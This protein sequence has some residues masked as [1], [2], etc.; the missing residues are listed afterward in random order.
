MLKHSLLP[1]WGMSAL[2]LKVC[3]ATVGLTLAVFMPVF[4]TGQTPPTGGVVTTQ[5]EF[6]LKDLEEGQGSAQRQPLFQAQKFLVAG[7]LDE[8]EPLI[9][10]V[11][12]YFD[13]ETAEKAVDYVSVASREQLERY[14]KEHPGERKIV[15][16]DWS[17]GWALH[18]KGWIAASRRRLPEAEKWL[19]K[20]V[21][22]RPYA[23]E[24][25]VELGYVQTQAGRGQDGLKTYERAIE[26]ARTIPMEK[27]A[28]PAALRGLGF[29]L[30]ELKDLPRA[31][32]AFRESLRIEPKSM[33]ARR[34][35]FYIAGLEKKW[36]EQEFGDLARN[37]R[38]AEVV[39]KLDRRIK[40][41]PED[42]TARV[43]R[44]TRLPN[45]R[46]GPAP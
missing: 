30:I 22:I 2:G 11:L 5:V 4:A 1:H 6:P 13:N 43:L 23:A 41:V 7:K 37:G 39:A 40:A 12:E 45:R 42:S 35:I 27:V 15:W 14:K 31:R 36:A 18:K 9:D 17:Y 34:E 21:A 3:L 24:S 44:E 19:K 10:K 16:L 32:K 28:E 8:A 46:S 29:T 26:L 20:A 25:F 38:W 33:L